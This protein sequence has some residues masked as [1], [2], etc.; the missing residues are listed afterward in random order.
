MSLLTSLVPV[1][2]LLLS[3]LF[4]GF[5]GENIFYQDK[6]TQ[7]SNLTYASLFTSFVLFCCCFFLIGWSGILVPRQDLLSLLTSSYLVLLLFSRALLLARSDSPC[8]A[9]MSS[10]CLSVRGRTPTPVPPHLDVLCHPECSK[11]ISPQIFCHPKFFSRGE[12]RRDTMLPS[13]LVFPTISVPCMAILA[14]RFRNKPV[15]TFNLNFVPGVQCNQ[16]TARFRA[17]SFKWKRK[18][19]L[20]QGLQKGV[21]CEI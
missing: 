18:V 7:N 5:S 8:H 19:W 17:E 13:I 6:G 11:K 1:L 2:L 21:S 10:V 12:A 4:V 14:P 20:K 16:S 15:W 3:C 9:V